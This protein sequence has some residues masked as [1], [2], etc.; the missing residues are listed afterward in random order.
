MPFGD[1]AGRVRARW[2]RRPFPGAQPVWFRGAVVTDLRGAGGD[3]AHVVRLPNSAR[4]RPLSARLDDVGLRASAEG[5][6]HGGDPLLRDHPHAA[7]AL[8]GPLWR[9]AAP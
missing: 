3:T 1:V 5:H 4:T 2:G 8:S 9:L 6:R 7:S